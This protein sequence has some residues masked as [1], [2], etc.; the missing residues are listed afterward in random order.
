MCR[1][2][3]QEVLGLSESI[4]FAGRPTCDWAPSVCHGAHLRLWGLFQQRGAILAF[5]AENAGGQIDLRLGLE[6][7]ML[8]NRLR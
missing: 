1:N 3:E 6:L 7:Q 4:V 2:F 5:G 8:G